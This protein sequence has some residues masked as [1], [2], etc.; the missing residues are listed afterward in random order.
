MDS[1]LASLLIGLAGALIGA[2]ASIATVWIQ[3]MVQDRRER[4]RLVTEL[5]LEDYKIQLKHAA[6]G[7]RVLP[8][9][10]FIDFHLRLAR[11]FERG[12]LTPERYEK[13]FRENEA[14]ISKIKSLNQAT[15]HSGG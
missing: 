6:P 1:T 3:G 10:M 14:L 13:V 4:L 12:V 2:S 11:E 7:S 15:G 9:S 8:I 5:A